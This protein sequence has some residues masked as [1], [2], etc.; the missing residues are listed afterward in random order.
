GPGLDPV[1]ALGVATVVMA[2]SIAMYAP[3]A[4]V[5]N[6]RLDQGTF[7]FSVQFGAT[8]LANVVFQYPIGRLSD[9]YGRRPFLVG[10]FVLLYTSY[11]GLRASIATDAVQAVIVIPLLLLAFAGTLV[12][13]GAP[14]AAIDGITAT[15]PALLDLGAVAGL[16]FGLALAGLREN[17]QRIAF[18]GYKAQHLKAIIFAVGGTIAGLAGSLYAFH[19]GFVWPNMLGVVF[20][21]Q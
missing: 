7:L 4:N 20:S 9:R 19:E 3:L 12:A 6:E 15:N 18:F 10:G 14:A 17:E 5:I 1:F 16:Q 2:L 21:T 11:G 13:L 8:V